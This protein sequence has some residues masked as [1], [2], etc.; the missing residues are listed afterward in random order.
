VLH[1]LNLEDDEPASFDSDPQQQMEEFVEKVVGREAYLLWGKSVI[2]TSELARTL[3]PHGGNTS[4]GVA[5]MG[6]C[7]GFVAN[8][9][10]P[11][12]YSQHLIWTS[13]E[14]VAGRRYLDGSPRL[15]GK[16]CL[17]LRTLLLSEMR[18]HSQ[19]SPCCNLTSALTPRTAIQLLPTIGCTNLSSSAFLGRRK[20]KS[21]P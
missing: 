12:A 16:H 10:L 15:N 19:A 6:R 14:A 9:D 18:M 4:R 11:S 17:Y 2:L 3:V 20:S 13:P 5:W 7:T 8:P 1:R 21:H